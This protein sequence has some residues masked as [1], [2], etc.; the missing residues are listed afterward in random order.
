MNIEP[1]TPVVD[2]YSNLDESAAA[3]AAALKN[4][5]ARSS[6]SAPNQVDVK[7]YGSSGAKAKTGLDLYMS[8]QLNLAGARKISGHDDK[9]AHFMN[10]PYKGME[11]GAAMEKIRSEYNNNPEL[12]K[13]FDAEAAR[14]NQ[15]NNL[16][17]LNMDA[18][19][20]PATPAPAPAPAI[21]LADPNSSTA[22][23][24]LDPFAPAP[25]PE[26]TTA[27]A[28][29]TAPKAAPKV[30]ELTPLPTPDPTS[31]TGGTASPLQ[32]PNAVGVSKL[33]LDAAAAVK[34]TIR[35][36]ANSTKAPPTRK[37]VGY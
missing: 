14:Q 29:A 1:I 13:G 17:G 16:G 28:T 22:P 11:L 36:A 24:G 33:P 9:G 8:Q 6:D 37:A 2:V 27:P 32:N 15:A 23:K 21:G 30:I 7:G 5:I 26:A 18:A 34:N 12:S 10:G 35:P 20:Q 3:D 4:K 19:T 31:T 25:A